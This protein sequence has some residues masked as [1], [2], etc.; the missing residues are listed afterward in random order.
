MI[1]YAENSLTV[2]YIMFQFIIS[3]VITVKGQIDFEMT[4]S[5][6]LTVQATE[7]ES[8]LSAT[9]LVIIQVLVSD[10]LN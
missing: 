9:T 6:N 8:G 7:T 1:C 4:P 2:V 3:G 5:Y 10:L